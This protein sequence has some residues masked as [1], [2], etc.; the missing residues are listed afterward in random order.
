MASLETWI[1]LRYLRAKKHS[2]FLSFITLISI[3]GITLGVAALITVLAVMSGFQKEIRTQLLNVAPHA[4]LGYFS[5]NATKPWQDLRKIYA[6]NPEVV[7]DAPYISDYALLANA[8]EVQ[9]AQ[10]NGI[11]PAQEKKI[12]DYWQKMTEG[13]F[14][15][16]KPGESGI[17]LGAELAKQLDA[18][19]GGMITVITPSGDANPDNVEPKLNQF[20]VVGIVKTGIFEVDKGLALTHLKDAQELYRFGDRVSGIR[21]KLAHPLDAPAFTGS[22]VLPK[23]REN[24]VW[25]RDWT[26]TSNSFFATVEFQKKMMFVILTLIIAVAAFNLVST[27]VMAV[28]EK[29]ADIAILRT[30]GLSPNGVMKVFIVQG[31]VA[32]FFGTLFGVIVGVLLGSYIG[33]VLAF[34]EKTFGFQLINSQ[35]Y[36]IDYLPS[37]VNL[38]D[39]L[40][41]AGFSLFLAL[42]ATLYPSW[43]AARTRPA[44]ALRY[45]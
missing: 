9:G 44:D 6:G 31:M 34:F 36:F 16:L 37:D 24:S 41:V 21:L 40:T 10:I 18:E 4:E 20:H 7:A 11:E 8:G 23:D 39:V 30:L 28:T 45:E 22:L 35:I 17:I 5:P 43:R 27:L 25:V 19:V 3:L 26:L 33:T 12:V 32:G 38:P 1:G 42:L 2:G 15:D 14:D 29:Q 13:S